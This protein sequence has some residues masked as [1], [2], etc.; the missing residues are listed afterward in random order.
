MDDRQAA[1]L[2]RFHARG[3][4]PADLGERMTPLCLTKAP[5]ATTLRVG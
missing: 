2:Y 4:N 5:F 3:R 1:R